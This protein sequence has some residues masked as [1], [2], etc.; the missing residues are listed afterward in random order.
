MDSALGELFWWCLQWA[1][2]LLQ[3]MQPLGYLEQGTA[4]HTAFHSNDVGTGS[5]AWLRPERLRRRLITSRVSFLFTALSHWYP[6]IICNKV[7]Y[8]IMKINPHPLRRKNL[9]RL[10]L[11]KRT[12]LKSRCHHA[13]PQENLNWQCSNKTSFIESYQWTACYLIK[14]KKWPVLSVLLNVRPYCHTYCSALNHIIILGKCFLYVHVLN[15]I[16]NRL[17]EFCLIRTWKNQC[18]KIHCSHF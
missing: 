6:H 2:S 8:L 18:R 15:N 11:R 12:W 9:Q 14:W 5:V 7:C 4:T 13:K 3:L 1:L 10:A 17:D 16:S